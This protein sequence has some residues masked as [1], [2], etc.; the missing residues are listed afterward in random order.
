M[1][2]KASAGA[3][4]ATI[5]DFLGEDQETISS[6]FIKGLVF[7]LGFGTVLL[8]AMLHCTVMVV[9]AILEATATTN[10]IINGFMLDLALYNEDDVRRDQKIIVYG[11]LLIVSLISFMQ[12]NRFYGELD[13]YGNGGS[14]KAKISEQGVED[15]EVNKGGSKAD[16]LA[17]NRV[18]GRAFKQ[19]EFANFSQNCSDAVEQVT[20]KTPSGVKTRVDAIG[21]L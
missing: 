11:T 18:N 5:A 8:F 21:L 16:V 17:Q 13:L 2:Q 12:V 4:S 1:T 14:A 6:E 7:G 9:A 15:I 20:I 3:I 19:Q 10:V